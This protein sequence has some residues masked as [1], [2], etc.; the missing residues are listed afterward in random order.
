MKIEFPKFVPIEYVQE[1]KSMDSDD[2]TIDDSQ[3]DCSPLIDEPIPD[4]YGPPSNIDDIYI[5]HKEDISDKIE[6]DEVELLKELK[7]RAT[8][9]SRKIDEP[10]SFVY[11]PPHRCSTRHGCLGTL[12]CDYEYASFND[13]D[14]NLKY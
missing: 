6:I 11:G 3:F 13:P 9:L 1:D 12:N 5:I 8:G 10:M 7:K 4:L 2:Y 14:P